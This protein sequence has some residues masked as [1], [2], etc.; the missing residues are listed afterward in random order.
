LTQRKANLGNLTPG[1]TLEFYD[2]TVE[3]RGEARVGS[4]EPLKDEG[5]IEQGIRVLN[6]E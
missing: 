2:E 1:E 5:L 3:P 6:P 4:I